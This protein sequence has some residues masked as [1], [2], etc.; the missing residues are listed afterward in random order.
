MGERVFFVHA[1][2]RR[3]RDFGSDHEFAHSGGHLWTLVIHLIRMALVL[4][5]WHN[6]STLY[7][8]KNPTTTTTYQYGLLRGGLGKATGCM[9]DT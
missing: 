3:C 4:L 8:K 1:E 2:L 5:T 6:A 7:T 9:S